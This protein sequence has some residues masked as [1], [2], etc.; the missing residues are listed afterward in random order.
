MPLFEYRCEHCQ[1]KFTLLEGVT[2]EKPKR[3]CP[4]CGGKKLTK[5]ISRVARPPKGEDS[6]EDADLEGMDDEGDFGDD[7]GDEDL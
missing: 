1:K 2:A 6:F 4:H 3:V 5:L 7:L